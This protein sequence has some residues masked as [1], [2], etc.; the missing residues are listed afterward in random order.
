MQDA[1]FSDQGEPEHQGFVVTKGTLKP[2]CAISVPE[3]EWPFHT[4][5]GKEL[6]MLA[7]HLTTVLPMFSVQWSLC[8]PE[9]WPVLL[10][11]NARSAIPLMD[12]PA[13]CHV[14]KVR[15]RGLPQKGS[16]AGCRNRRRGPGGKEQRR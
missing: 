4:V 13:G 9:H 7:S 6:V 15:V 16:A 3:R 2:R 12:H 11:Q 8:S 10:P 1:Y 5:A 14:R